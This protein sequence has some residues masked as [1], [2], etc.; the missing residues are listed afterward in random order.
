MLFLMQPHI[1]PF[2]CHKST[3]T[4]QIDSY[5]VSKSKLKPDQC[6][7][8]KTKMIE[9]TAP[10]QQPHKPGTFFWDALYVSI[11]EK[12]TAA[13]CIQSIDQFNIIR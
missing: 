8:V 11:K 6:N 7:C 1:L 4:C 10:P 3:T 9:S 12:G 5:K 13:F 2:L